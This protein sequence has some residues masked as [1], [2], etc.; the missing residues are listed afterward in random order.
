MKPGSFLVCIIMLIFLGG[1]H[2]VCA[3]KIKLSVAGFKTGCIVGDCENGKGVLAFIMVQKNPDF[4]NEYI[5]QTW[6]V[7]VTMGYLVAEFNAK[8]KTARGTIYGI[9][10]VLYYKRKKGSEPMELTLYSVSSSNKFEPVEIVRSDYN[11][12]LT[13]Y[14]QLINPNSKKEFFM[15]YPVFEGTLKY[16]GLSDFY[17][18]KQLTF[19]DADMAGF[20]VGH[21]TPLQGIFYANNIGYEFDGI[22]ADNF[23]FRGTIQ[24]QQS[25][26]GSKHWTWNIADTVFTKFSG[27][28]DY[29]Y[30]SIMQQQRLLFIPKRGKFSSFSHNKTIE[31]VFTKEQNPIGLLIS[32]ENDKV[33]DISLYDIAQRKYKSATGVTN[34]KE[35]Y[36]EKLPQMRKRIKPNGY[37]DSLYYEG[38]HKNGVPNGLGMLFYEV[39]ENKPAKINAETLYWGFFKDGVPE[40]PGSYIKTPDSNMTIVGTYK[41]GVLIHGSDGVY[42]GDFVAGEYSGQ[43]KFEKGNIVYEG[44]FLGGK[45]N[46]FGHWKYKEIENGEPFYQTY[47]GLFADGQF[48]GKGKFT[49]SKETLEGIFEFGRLKEGSKITEP[50]GNIT[51]GVV[52]QYTCGT[53]KGKSFVKRV[54][55]NTGMITMANREEID[56]KKCKID[57]LNEN[58]DQFY[59]VCT[60][61]HGSG[62]VKKVTSTPTNG[63]TTNTSFFGGNTIS[64]PSTT[65]TYSRIYITTTTTEKCSVCEGAGRILKFFH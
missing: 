45:F 65:T 7:D 2:V 49:S 51:S 18:Q 38:Q 19:N 29:D 25:K 57:I 9:S 17:S 37:S 40:G 11:N 60:V 63:Y 6:G 3:Q 61:C 56:F 32:Y 64:G 15:N 5:W 46:G 48:N 1:N 30:V 21:F 33:S 13:K 41:N 22:F 44:N 20:F 53:H 59:S 35:L 55:Y 50:I 16:T 34:F 26:Q 39:T 47:T 27:A 31:G 8:E 52:V 4:T 14:D 62:S 23:P 54:S 58:I 36:D 43:G 28:F 12:A 24:V 42:L 10:D